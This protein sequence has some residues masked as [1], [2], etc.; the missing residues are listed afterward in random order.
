MRRNHR[1]QPHPADELFQV[2]VI[3]K[4]WITSQRD[5]ISRARLIGDDYRK[6]RGLA[7]GAA[8]QS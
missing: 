8:V 3:L 6:K 1:V 2:R 5:R 7:S 4:T